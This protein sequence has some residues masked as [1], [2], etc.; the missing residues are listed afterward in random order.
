METTTV[1][2]VTAAIEQA[3]K[4]AKKPRRTVSVGFSGP[5]GASLR[6]SLRISKDGKSATTW[7]SH[8]ASK[9]AKS[10]RGAT[11]NHATLAVAEEAFGKLAEK[12]LKLGWVRRERKGF[13][14]QPDGFTE[15]PTP[16]KAKGKK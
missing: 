3:A 6:I 5:E 16:V 8:K 7:A 1:E 12:A 9:A 14:R 11:Q 15:I 2:Q 10:T 4:P 13:V